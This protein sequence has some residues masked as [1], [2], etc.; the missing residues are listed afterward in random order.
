M[1]HVLA[2]ALLG[3]SPGLTPRTQ[4][5]WRAPAARMAKGSE[6]IAFPEL[7]G[8][9]L[10]VG[11]IRARWHEKT[12]DN[13]VSGIRAALSECSV[14]EENVFI[15]EVPGAFELPLASRFLAL[16]QTV[17]VIV[18]VGVLIKGDTAHFELISDAVTKGLMDVGLS[19]GVP[20]I[21]GVL[22]VDNDQQ[23]K[24]RSTGANNHGV[25]WGK[26]AVEMA[27]LRRSAKGMKKKFFMGFGDETTMED[28]GSMGARVG[29]GKKISF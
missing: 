3:F 28:T 1:L 29:E 8:A 22:T 12:G 4:A 20:V 9:D 5:M 10:R 23:A 13:L 2:A 25:Q 27:L 17:D 16:S 21:F 14:P 19:T 18:P 24:E 11:I 15:T 26:A 7:D 6:A